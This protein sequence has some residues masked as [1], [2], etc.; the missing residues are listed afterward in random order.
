[1]MFTLK[2]PHKTCYLI[3][4]PLIWMPYIK[5]LMFFKT[6]SISSRLVKKLK[7]LTLAHFEGFDL[8]FGGA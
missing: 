5:L 1:M 6:K 4:Y 3:L 2:R 7:D 8:V